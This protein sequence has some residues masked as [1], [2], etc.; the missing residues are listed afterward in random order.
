MKRMNFLNTRMSDKRQSFLHKMASKKEEYYTNLSKLEE[1][2]TA[3]NSKGHRSGHII[4]LV[5]VNRYGCVLMGKHR[6]HSHAE[7]F[8][9]YAQEDET[10]KETVLREFSQQTLDCIM[11][12]QELEA[13]LMSQTSMI[14]MHES[15]KGRR[16][17]VVFETKKHL[18]SMKECQE[19]FLLKSKSL[20]SARAEQQKYSSLIAVLWYNFSEDDRRDGK[21]MQTTDTDNN[22]V[23][24]S[25][26]QMPAFRR[27]IHPELRGRP[28]TREEKWSLQFMEDMY[29]KNIAR[30]MNMATQKRTFPGY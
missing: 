24:V 4:V 23:S 8:G 17:I 29:E 27:M 12:S 5:N 7:M 19:M 25:S 22:P 11:T 6:T 16:Y 28:K 14:L 10:L 1:L 30:P 3:F 9:G 18:S 15:R 13:H 21:N 26:V 20:D 2:R